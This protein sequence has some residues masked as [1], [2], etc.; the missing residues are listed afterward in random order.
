MINIDNVTG[1]VMNAKTTLGYLLARYTDRH[2]GD[3]KV[4]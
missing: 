1:A 2:T 3:R 4:Q